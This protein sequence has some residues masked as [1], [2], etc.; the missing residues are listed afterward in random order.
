MQRKGD[1][2]RDYL[3]IEHAPIHQSI[4]N[5]SY[6]YIWFV[7]DGREQFFDLGRDPDEL[8]DLI[9]DKEYKNII[10][11]YRDIMIKILEN[12]PEGFT[13]G[14]KLISGRE[15]NSALNTFR[16]HPEH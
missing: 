9:G 16:C 15:Y 2:V 10:S 12:R 3:H 13:D 11:K 1:K 8:S 6:K 7:E 4:T 14:K 5:G